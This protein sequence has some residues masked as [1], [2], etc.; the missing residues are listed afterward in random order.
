MTRNNKIIKKSASDEINSPH[1]LAGCA[2]DASVP[3]ECGALSACL[4]WLDDTIRNA[5]RMAASVYG[6]E[7][8]NDPFR[9]LHIT[10][11]EFAG[12][13]DRKA[14]VPLFAGAGIT[15]RLGGVP[16][17]PSFEQ[18]VRTCTLDPFD[19]AVLLIAAAPEIDLRYEKLYAYLQDDVSK[20]R[21]CID[22]TLDLS[23]CR[24]GTKI[25]DAVTLSR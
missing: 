25:A 2:T 4:E 17:P 1:R 9:G 12:L 5:M 21:P 8:N 16:I 15:E 6:P 3:N 22:L 10:P 20:K 11:R 7:A 13:L 19:I 23:L 14:G 24:H 18:L